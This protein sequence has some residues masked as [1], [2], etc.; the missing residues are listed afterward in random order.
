MS[1]HVL[2]LCTANMYRSRLAEILFNHYAKQS[3]M[4]W[5]AVSRAIADPSGLKGMSSL[6]TNY[7]NLRGLGQLAEEPR[8]PKRVGVEELESSSLAIAMCRSEHEPILLNTFGGLVRKRIAEN[9]LRFWNVYDSQ[10]RLPFPLGLIARFG[11]PQTQ[12]ASSGTEHIDFAVQA[13]ISELKG[14]TP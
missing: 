5:S 1:C 4:E 3:G 8:D 9:R 10:L 14:K 13:L 12:H 2:F 11:E 6:T 7:L